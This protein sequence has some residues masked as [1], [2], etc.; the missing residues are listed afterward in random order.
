MLCLS[1]PLAYEAIAKS[2]PLGDPLL[3]ELVQTHAVGLQ[4][5]LSRLATGRI[6]FENTETWR[7]AYEKVFVRR[8]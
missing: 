8:A 7:T 3:V 4:E 1:S 5:E 2:L 6:I